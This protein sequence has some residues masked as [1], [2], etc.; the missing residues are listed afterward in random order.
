MY[1]TENQNYHNDHRVRSQNRKAWF[2]TVDSAQMKAVVSLRHDDEETGDE[3]EEDVEVPIKFEVCP[4]CD[5]RG[6]HVNPSV[7]SNGLTAEDFVEDPD[8]RE[9][10]FSGRYDVTCYGCGGKN[11]VPVINSDH[12]D[13]ETRKLLDKVQEQREADARYEQQCARERAMGY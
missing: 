13:D 1:S 6:T 12:V 5:G 8:F 9:D 2:K 11:V 3:I 10:Y 4:T 7:D